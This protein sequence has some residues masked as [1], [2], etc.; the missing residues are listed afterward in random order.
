MLFP[1]FG[2]F[3]FLPCRIPIIHEA[4]PAMLE[5]SNV[6]TM[7]STSFCAIVLANADPM[8]SCE[9]RAMRRFAPQEEALWPI[10]V[11]SRRFE[12][13]RNALCRIRTRKLLN[14]GTQCYISRTR[15]KISFIV[16]RALCGNY[17]AM[18]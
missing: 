16:H 15:R 13:L 1:Q 4:P 18:L 8:A 5:L 6:Q 17:A 10:T 3:T 14:C 2:L 12:L 9:R 7:P 11:P